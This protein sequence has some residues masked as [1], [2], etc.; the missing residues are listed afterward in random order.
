MLNKPLWLCFCYK[1]NVHPTVVDLIYGYE[2]Y[3]LFPVGR[4]DL[5]TEGLLLLTNDGDLHISY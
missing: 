3:D 5:D 2:Q 1:D 4:L